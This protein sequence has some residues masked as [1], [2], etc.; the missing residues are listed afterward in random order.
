MT[1]EDKQPAPVYTMVY[2]I[3]KSQI[4]E[5]E[6]LFAMPE[7]AMDEEDYEAQKEVIAA[8]L[9][10]PVS[11]PPEEAAPDYE[12]CGNM[13]SDGEHDCNYR[14]THCNF[15][16]TRHC[17]DFIPCTCEYCDGTVHNA[18]IAQAAREKAL[19]EVQD[20]CDEKSWEIDTHSDDGFQQIV[21]CSEIDKI[22]ESL[23][24]PEQEQPAQTERTCYGCS[25]YRIQPD[26]TFTPYCKAHPEKGKINPDH[27]PDWCKKE[28]RP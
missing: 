2:T 17:R 9:S 5:I 14:G 1:T 8:I 15:T 6:R 12:H 25:E 27:S 4:E 19:N 21:Y 3:T 26:L 23:R 28:T 24:Q 22:I 20:R 11:I 7:H 13:S 18:A 10:C 16:H